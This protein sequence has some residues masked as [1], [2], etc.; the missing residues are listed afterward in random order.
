MAE[1]SRGGL[2]GPP[3]LDPPGPAETTHTWLCPRCPRAVIY[4]AP[5][6]GL[7]SPPPLRSANLPLSFMLQVPALGS[8]P[9]P[10]SPSHLTPTSHGEAWAWARHGRLWPPSPSSL[11]AEHWL[12]ECRKRW[13]GQLSSESTYLPAPIKSTTKHPHTCAQLQAAGDPV[14]IRLSPSSG[15]RRW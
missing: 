14:P 12:N 5:C 13:G 9:Q 1:S 4:T 8:L 7:L 2:H 15:K 3:S 6:L 10:Q 11:G